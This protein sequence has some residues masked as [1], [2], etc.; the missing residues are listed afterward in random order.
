MI[1]YIFIEDFVWC[2][3]F[4][5]IYSLRITFPQAFEQSCQ[6]SAPKPAVA[7]YMSRTLR[8]YDNKF[9]P[10][11]FSNVNVQQKLAYEYMCT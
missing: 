1:D 10:L 9:S 3:G 5:D 11:I 8:F 7:L 6:F 2:S 4:H